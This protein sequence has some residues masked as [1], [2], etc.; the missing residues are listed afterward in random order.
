[1]IYTSH[2]KLILLQ[3]TNY[4]K[5]L[6]YDYNNMMIQRIAQYIPL[7][8]KFIRNSQPISLGRWHLDDCPKKTETKAHWANEDHCG[9]CGYTQIKNNNIEQKKAYN[10]KKDPKN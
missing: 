10:Y 6:L 8:K 4:L 7:V 1:M 2:L 5:I 3:V 9:P